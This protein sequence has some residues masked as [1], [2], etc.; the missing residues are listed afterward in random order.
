MNK[1]LLRKAFIVIILLL[2]L[3]MAYS[4]VNIYAIFYS[5]GTANIVQENATWKVIVNGT[6]IATNNTFNVN[7]FEIEENTHVAE[8][9]IAPSVTGSFYIEIVPQDTDVSIKYDIKLDNSNLTNKQINIVSIEEIN[10]N[11][12]LTLTAE[13]TY[14]GLLKLEDIKKGITDK[15]KVTIE[16]K[17]DE[18]NNSQ[19]TLIGT[20][21]N[22]NM[23][24]PVSVHVV[25]Y[26]GEEITEYNNT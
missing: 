14:T 10:N 7:S 11:S 19:D 16:W 1:K 23:D 20:T 25:Q 5:E 3:I 4:L 2:V 21:P 24:I 13:N 8:G 15:I 17:N 12:K 26:L 22:Y 18:N 6:N 9:M